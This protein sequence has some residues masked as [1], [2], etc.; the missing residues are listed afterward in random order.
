MGGIRAGGV[1][2]QSSQCQLIGLQEELGFV[3][4]VGVQGVKAEE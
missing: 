1:E 3:D 4:D 2:V